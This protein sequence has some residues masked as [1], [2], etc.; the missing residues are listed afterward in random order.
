MII[1]AEAEEAQAAASGQWFWDAQY[2]R[3]RMFNPTTRTWTW[4]T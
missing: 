1:E 2:E 4:Q 3:Y